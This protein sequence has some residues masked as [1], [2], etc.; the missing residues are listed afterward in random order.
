METIKSLKHLRFINQE[1]NTL[2]LE[3][4][5]QQFQILIPTDSDGF[6]MIEMPIVLK[7]FQWLSRV[8]EYI[9]DRQPSLS[10]L[11]KYIDNKYE[12]ETQKNVKSNQILFDIPELKVSQF[13]LEEQKY[14]KKL[15]TELDKYKSS[16]TLTSDTN[17]T[18]ALFS[19]KT[20]GL[21]II[22]EFFNIRKKYASN[23]RIELNLVDHNIYHW[24]IKFRYFENKKLSEEL[25]KLEEQ[26]GYNYVEIEIHFHDK[27]Y[28]A[29]PPFIRPVR[30]RLCNGLMNRITNIKMTQLDYW[31]PSRTMD[32]VVGKLLS[33]LDKHCVVDYESDMNDMAKYSKGSYHSLE[34]VLIKM[35][36]FCDIK[37]DMEP[38]DDEEYK[39]F[40]NVKIKNTTEIPQKKTK[41][42]A[43]SS[44]TGYGHSGTRNWDPNEYVQLQ[45]EKDSQI[46]SVINNII[47]HMN[48]YKQDEM[49]TVYNILNSSY[50]IPFIKNYIRG[51]N[52][53]DMSSHMEMYKLLLTFMQLLATDESIFIFDNQNGNISLYQILT[54]LY[55]E[56]KSVIALSKDTNNTDEDIAQMICV[57][58]EMIQPIY[59]LYIEKQKKKCEEGQQ[60]WN[61]KMELLKNNVDSVNSE[62]KK[63]M[64][65]L[66]FGVCNFK[67]FHYEIPNTGGLKQTMIKRIARECGAFTNSLPIFFESSI[68][69]RINEKDSRAMKILITG[70]DGTPYDSGCLIFDLYTGNDYPNANPSMIFLNHGKKR[71]N[72]NLYNCGKV[73]L[74]LLGTWGGTGGETWNATTSTLQ[75]LFVSIQS[76]ILV[77]EP[78]YNEP[79]YES[80][81]NNP[82]GKEESRQY[83]NR[84]KIYTLHHTMYDLLVKPDAYPEFTEIIKMHFK[85]KKD[86]IKNLCDT[87]IKEPNNKFEKET[88]EIA[89]KVK[90]ELDKL[91]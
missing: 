13:D 19:G 82:A 47:D 11:L 86:Y 1:A 39:Q 44:G 17:K 29:Y 85:L 80:N 89:D 78:F 68:F 62:Y 37:D 66:N 14:K 74:S 21:L 49:I 46:Q 35:A 84:R 72:P 31:T 16:L 2:N 75:Q 64:G 25:K 73:C 40:Q 15:E 45:K 56:A 69:V 41:D 71:F 50:L 18:S 10:D 87:W 53:L 20:P 63:I 30:P 65:E 33:I 5:I 12:L 9:F 7:D 36:S 70:P 38:L 4:G 67:A 48:T 79:H 81:Y 58:Y 60:N 90:L 26:Y 32:F 43:W 55:K 42:T 24:N 28:P 8:N 54:A 3:I 51:S 61:N 77:P 57:V 6:H 27:L 88:K 22:N 76:Q 59:N 52:L 83:T 91:N 34:A 23:S